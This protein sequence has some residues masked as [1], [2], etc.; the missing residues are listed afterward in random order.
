MCARLD[1]KTALRSWLHLSPALDAP[2]KFRTA[3][4]PLIFS[5]SAP[6]GSPSRSHV[7]GFHATLTILPASLFCPDLPFSSWR[8]SLP[9]LLSSFFAPVRTSR[10]TVCPSRTSEFVS[11]V[12]TSPLDPAITTVIDSPSLSRQLPPSHAPM[13]RPGLPRAL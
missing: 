2:A 12:P 1:R 7:F 13:P 11:A 9:L 3:S 4:A 5:P 10:T 8:S 6:N